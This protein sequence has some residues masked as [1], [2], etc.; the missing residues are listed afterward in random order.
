MKKLAD[1]R[2]SPSAQKRSRRRGAG[3]FFRG[4]KSYFGGRQSGIAD[5]LE[6]KVRRACG[7]SRLENIFQFFA[8]YP[9]WLGEHFRLQAWRVPFC[10]ASKWPY[11]RLRSLFWSKN[12]EF[13]PFFSFWVDTFATYGV[14]YNIIN[15]LST[16]LVRFFNFQKDNK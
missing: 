9:V 2:I 1:G 11:G 6:N 12:R 16:Y 3:K 5:E 14:V 8:C 7:L 4:G 13:W 15:R 10:D